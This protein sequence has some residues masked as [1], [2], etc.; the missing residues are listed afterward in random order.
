[1]TTPISELIYTD[2]KVGNLTRKKPAFC[3]IP[4][5][6]PNSTI[7]F[8]KG[9]GDNGCDKIS[10]E[11]KEPIICNRQYNPVCG[12]DGTTYVN[13]CSA[14]KAGIKTFTFGKCEIED[15]GL[16]ATN[17]PNFACVIKPEIVCGIDG[18]TY[19]HPK[20]AECVGVAIAY[21]GSCKPSP[22]SPPPPPPRPTPPK[23]PIEPVICNQQY[24]PVCGSDGITY[25]NQCLAN[26]AGINDFTQG[27]CIQNGPTPNPSNPSSPNPSNP[28]NIPNVPGDDVGNPGG[29]VDGGPP[30]FGGGGGNAGGG[31]GFCNV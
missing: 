26:K 5:C 6:A 15:C 22:P 8:Q 14:Y 18:K 21:E 2:N 3:P 17:K 7:V 23:P 25:N 20:L 24:D 16:C 12:S 29:D 11:P 30:V 13:P 1:M 28:D 10:C 4:V 9:S 27:K 31:P 19:I